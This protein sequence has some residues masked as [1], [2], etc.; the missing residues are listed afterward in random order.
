[1]F[2]KTS[3]RVQ[4]AYLLNETARFFFVV[5]VFLNRT[6]SSNSPFLEIKD[7][8]LG[9][10]DRTRG[11]V[12]ELGPHWA[13][14]LDGHACYWAQEP[15]LGEAWMCDASPGDRRLA[16]ERDLWGRFSQQTAVLRFPFCRQGSSCPS[17]VGSYGLSYSTCSVWGFSFRKSGS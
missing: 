15:S 7:W 2:Y 5:V 9:R 13:P 8:N 17:L 11:A 1:M 6:P 4:K 14:H 12:T 3:E 16:G 10:K